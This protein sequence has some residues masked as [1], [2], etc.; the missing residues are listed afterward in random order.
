MTE[1]AENGVAKCVVSNHV[2]ELTQE[3]HAALLSAARGTQ[4]EKIAEEMGISY[5]AVFKLLNSAK[6]KLGARN[7][8][9]A[10][11]LASKLGII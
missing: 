6:D 2:I 4:R 8:Y 11:F 3:Q 7:I 9:H 5:M 1:S 10:I